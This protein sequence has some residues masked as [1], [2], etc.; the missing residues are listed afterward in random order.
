MSLAGGDPAVKLRSNRQLVRSS[1]TIAASGDD[2]ARDALHGSHSRSSSANEPPISY[3]PSEQSHP[4]PPS[5]PASIVDVGLR[6]ADD[7][8]LRRNWSQM[9]T[10]E[11]EHEGASR[12]N[13]NATLSIGEG[14]FDLEKS[15]RHVVK[16]YVR[17]GE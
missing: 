7:S 5:S 4:R 13:S 10:D 15:L 8:E 16:M 2:V 17:L 9:S 3:F 12:A 6:T 14:R 1:P 11:K